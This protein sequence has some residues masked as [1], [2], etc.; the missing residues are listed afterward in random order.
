[1]V[2]L[3][4]EGVASSGKVVTL[5]TQLVLLREDKVTW[6]DLVGFDGSSIMVLS[7]RVSFVSA[8]LFNKL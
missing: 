5:D 4:R 1:M 3:G 6:I 7:V 2:L 8:L